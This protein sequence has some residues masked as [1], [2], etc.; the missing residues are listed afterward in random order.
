[1]IKYLEDQLYQKTK[2]SQSEILFAQWNYDKKIIPTALHAVS[3]LFPHYSLHDE[4]HSVTIINNIVR[5]IGKDNIPKLSAIDIWLILEASYCHDIGMV[6]SSDSILKS[7]NSEDFIGYFK[8]LEKD[9]KNGLYEFCKQFTIRDNKIILKEEIF[10]LEIIDGM[11]FILAEYFRRKHADRSKEII[12]NPALEL[13][14][15]SPRSVIPPRIF[16]LLGEICSCHTK[17]F[18]EVM[19]L[20]FS[21]VGIDVEDAHPR[22]IACLL[23]VG[24]LL[25]LDN[26]RFSEVM[27]RT[28]SKIP[29]DTLNHK[30][31]HLSIESFRV[32]KDKIEIAAKCDNYDTANITQHW[33]NYLNSEISQQMINWNDIVPFKELCYLPTIGKLQVELKGYDY[34]D[35]KNKPKF[36]VDTDKALALLQGAGIYNGPHQS[37][38]E[39]LQNAVDATLVRIWLEYGHNKDFTYPSNNE[40]I[41]IIKDFSIDVLITKIKTDRNSQT[42]RIEFKDKGVGISMKDLKFL[43]NTGSSSK[44]RNKTDIIESMP[45]WMRPSGT[46]GIGFQSVF[47]LTEVVNIETKNF[48]DEEYYTLELNNPNSNKDGDILIQ[49][50]DSNHSIKP[51]TV[52]SFNYIT[53]KFT[54]ISRSPY[55]QSYTDTIVTNYDPFIHE[56]MDLDIASVI[57]AV[58]EFSS[59]SYFSIN[60]VVEGVPMISQSAIN[61]KFNYFDNIS[62]YEINIYRNSTDYDSEFILYYKNQYVDTPSAYHFL[63]FEVNIHSDNANKVLTLSRNTVKS[64]YIDDFNKLFLNAVFKIII[65]NFESIFVT[66]EQKIYASMFLWYY[67]TEDIIYNIEPF[68]HWEEKQIEISKD[69]NISLKELMTSIE[70]FSIT[71][72]RKNPKRFIIDGNAFTINKHTNHDNSEIEIFI[73]KML[74]LKMKSIAEYKFR[75]EGYRKYD[76]ITFSIHEQLENPISLQDLYRWTKNSTSY[77]YRNLSSRLIIPCLKEY[78]KLRLKTE[79]EIL[80][81]DEFLIEEEL[82]LNFPKMLSPYVQIRSDKDKKF[83][84]SVNEKFYDWV[85]ENRCDER[86]TKK[87]IIEGYLEFIEKNQMIIES[88]NNQ[89]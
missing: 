86:V 61:K 20:P 2:D 4:T 14:I 84:L 74:G 41:E 27:L 37:I 69:K 36:T 76:K 22:F 62:N 17:D 81:V 19:K 68:R 75:E 43:M 82:N 11:R 40:F 56:S 30:S 87:D 13:S 70:I 33:F 53:E 44:N 24:D 57:D 60:L 5:V 51:S 26:N 52:V 8:E 1:M 47:M 28:L 79:F 31:K 88:L 59:K 50:K 65:E 64:S 71:H 38:R 73:Q 46:F 78:I 89:S 48:F 39:I 66:S 45:I 10:S 34:I 67:K 7:L 3:N 55:Y 77:Y 32:D 12:I 42:W 25:D 58:I 15:L 72:D 6:V 29:I 54:K 49:K 63:D 35:G 85:F 18:K 80:N 83:E 9:P 16:K 23:R 21:E